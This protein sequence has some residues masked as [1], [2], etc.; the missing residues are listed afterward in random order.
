MLVFFTNRK[1]EEER[2]MRES[3]IYLLSVMHLLLN[4]ANF[5][6]GGELCIKVEINQHAGLKLNGYYHLYLSLT[7]KMNCE[8]HH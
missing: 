6:H 4:H 3:K 1:K 7:A 2:K 8:I 5:S